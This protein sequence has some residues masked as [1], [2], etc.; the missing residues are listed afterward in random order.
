[1]TKKGSA[2]AGKEVCFLAIEE[3]D[4][5]EREGISYYED[6]IRFFAHVSKE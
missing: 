2:G 3:I 5:E 6:E 1:L 4:E